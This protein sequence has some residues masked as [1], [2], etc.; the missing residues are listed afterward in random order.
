M[1]YARRGPPSRARRRAPDLGAMVLL[2]WVTR[3]GIGSGL[4]VI[5]AAGL[6]FARLLYGPLSVSWLVGPVAQAIG[7]EAG[8][9]RVDIGD[10]AVHGD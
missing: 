4:A 5:L 6:L 10:N 7:E 9:V 1:P 2:R 8:G 3:I